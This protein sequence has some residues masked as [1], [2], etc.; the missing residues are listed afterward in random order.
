MMYYLYSFISLKLLFSR[1]G[2]KRNN[3]YIYIYIYIYIAISHRQISTS[4]AKK[5]L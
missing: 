4:I 5:K 3:E 1:A 2:F